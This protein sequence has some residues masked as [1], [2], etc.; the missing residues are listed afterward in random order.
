MPANDTDTRPMHASSV[1]RRPSF[2]GGGPPAG[3]DMYRRDA[4]FAVVAL[5]V[6]VAVGARLAGAGVF[7]TPLAVTVGVAGAL[8]IEAVFLRYPDVLLPVWERTGVAVASAVLVL[9]GGVV[10]VRYVPWLVGAAAWGLVVYLV[11]SALVLAG[12]GNPVAAVVSPRSE[13]D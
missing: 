9:V 5:A 3:M 11:L 2:H 8:A 13:R 6:L 4:L 12:V 10:A 1:P 7:L